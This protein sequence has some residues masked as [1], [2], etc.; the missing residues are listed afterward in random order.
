[1]TNLLYI[2]YLI[3]CIGVFIY[4]M[5]DSHTSTIHLSYIEYVIIA[6][7]L[8]VVAPVGLVII[9]IG[10]PFYGLHRLFHR[11]DVKPVNSDSDEDAPQ[12][13]DYEEHEDWCDGNTEYED[14]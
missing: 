7:V 14:E 1:M 12:G 13:F 4:F 9:A 6:L 5:M 8:S 2:I 3:I 10:Y 11:N